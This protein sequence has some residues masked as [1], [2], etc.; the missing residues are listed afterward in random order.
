M[1]PLWR[2]SLQSVTLESLPT[3][4]FLVGMWGGRLLLRAGVSHQ[5]KP[6]TG[7]GSVALSPGT[8]P[9][10]LFYSVS[11]TDSPQSHS[12]PVHSPYV[13]LTVLCLACQQHIQLPDA[14]HTLPA[15]HPS[16]QRFV[17]KVNP[18]L[19]TSVPWC[20]KSP[21]L[22]PVTSKAMAY[23][24]PPSLISAGSPYRSS[25]SC[26]TEPPVLLQAEQGFFCPRAFALP[27]LLCKLLFSASR[28]MPHCLN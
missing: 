23:S 2:V 17:C 11:S 6:E 15:Q 14:P 18:R 28:R 8:V 25:Y 12:Q 26:H 20:E 21:K 4:Q 5:L 9:V 24:F 13:T 27:F 1:W 7:S 22:L 3:P 16:N 10:C 19:T